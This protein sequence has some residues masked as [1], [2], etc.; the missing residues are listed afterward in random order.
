MTVHRHRHDRTPW[1]NCGEMIAAAKRITFLCVCVLL[2]CNIISSSLSMLLYTR[3]QKQNHT[4]MPFVLRKTRLANGARAAA[5]GAC[6]R[7]DRL[8]RDPGAMDVQRAQGGAASPQGRKVCI[9][10]VGGRCCSLRQRFV[11]LKKQMVGRRDADVQRVGNA[12]SSV[13][14]QQGG[15]SKGWLA[16]G[17]TTKRCLSRRGSWSVGW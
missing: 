15:F 13:P 3:A 5:A 8:G 4:I 17:K 1:R 6:D 11:P 14:D 16:K 2:N 12:Q 10:W 9:V 7:W